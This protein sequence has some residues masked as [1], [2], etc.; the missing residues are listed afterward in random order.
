LVIL[1]FIYKGSKLFKTKP[2]RSTGQALTPREGAA[3]R[4]YRK[5]IGEQLGFSF[6][7]SVEETEVW[8]AGRRAEGI[9]CRLVVRTWTEAPSPRTVFTW[10]WQEDVDATSLDYSVEV[11]EAV[12]GGS[13]VVCVIRLKVPTGE[14]YVWL[15]RGPP[16]ELRALLEKEAKRVGVTG[17]PFQHSQKGGIFLHSAVWKRLKETLASG[18]P[19]Y[20]RIR[21]ALEESIHVLDRPAPPSTS[22]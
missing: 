1:S 20:E 5:A 2:P 10:L 9:A 14:H 17:A 12:A 15:R 7:L 18:E 16:P 13:P 6:P 22:L 21:Q 11:S 3:A 19:L 4:R 8:D